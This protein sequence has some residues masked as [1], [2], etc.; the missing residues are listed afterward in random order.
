MVILIQTN[1][2]YSELL[3]NLANSDRILI[4]ITTNNYLYPTLTEFSLLFVYDLTNNMSYLVSLNHP[5][6]HQVSDIWQLIGDK[7]IK[8]FIWNKKGFFHNFQLEHNEDYKSYMN[9][10]IDINL[11]H[12]FKTNKSFEFNLNNTVAHNI[13]TNWYSDA[14]ELSNIIPATKHAEVVQDKLDDILN[15]VD[16][17]YIE[18]LYQDVSF[19]FFNSK[20][21]SVLGRIEQSGLKVDSDIFDKFF[22]YPY[23]KNDLVYT[24]YNL[25]TSTGRPSNRFGGVNFAALNK[26]DGSRTSFISRYNEDGIL[27]EFDWDSHHLRIIGQL[28]GYKL[29]MESMHEYL[30][31]QY[32]GVTNRELT[33]DEYSESKKISFQLLYGGIPREFEEIPFLKQTSEFIDK[34]WDLWEKYEYIICPLSKKKIY[35]K[36]FGEDEINKQKLFNYLIQLYELTKNILVIEKLLD[37]IKEYD[38]KLILYTYDSLLFDIKIGNNIKEIVGKIKDIMENNGTFPIKYKVGNSYGTM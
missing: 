37:T 1:K 33:E 17:Y 38:C 13:I 8:C 16:Y 10:I 4:P 35:K 29:P 26:E 5:D 28:I 3:E 30:G 34:L 22:D 12:W 36:N 24:E 20:V 27:A 11:I 7:D 23:Y 31:K 2:Q 9:N 15:I 6:L 14:E 19:A 25:Y 21:V 32:F 18:K